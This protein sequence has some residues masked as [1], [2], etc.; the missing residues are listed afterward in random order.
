MLV[1]STVCTASAVPLV[2]TAIVGILPLLVLISVTPGRRAGNAGREAAGPPGPGPKRQPVKTRRAAPHGHRAGSVCRV[3]DSTKPALGTCSLAASRMGGNL[4]L[5]S[6]TTRAVRPAPWPR[7]WQVPRGQWQCGPPPRPLP[8]RVPKRLASGEGRRTRPLPLYPR[9]R[10]PAPA[11]GKPGE[12]TGSP[13][14]GNDEH[15]IDRHVRKL[16]VPVY[17]PVSPPQKGGP[18]ATLPAERQVVWWHSISC[19][20]R[21]CLEHDLFATVIGP[22]PASWQILPDG[23]KG[24]GPTATSDVRRRP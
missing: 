24:P 20:C 21:L 14:T 4:C 1:A 8:A 5:L 11:P 18:M 9:P 12:A 19:V 17:G 13:R 16:P 15:H 2:V 6:L 22:L 3:R 7:P 10:A 23:G